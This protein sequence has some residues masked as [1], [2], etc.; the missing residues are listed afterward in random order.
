MTAM[1]PR[2]RGE[3]TQPRMGSVAPEENEASLA[4]S[5]RGALEGYLG[6]RRLVMVKIRQVE[7]S[8]VE[9]FLKIEGARGERLLVDFEATTH[10]GA[11]SSLH[12]GGRKISL[13]VGPTQKRTR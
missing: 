9:G 10:E 13:V 4:R 6:G 3:R 1:V 12:V 8:R 5:I 11:L 7:G 2:L